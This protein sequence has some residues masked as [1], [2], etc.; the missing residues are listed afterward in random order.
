MKK[1]QDVNR[2]AIDNMKNKI[3]NELGVDIEKDK[4]KKYDIDFIEK[5]METF[6]N[7]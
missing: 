6:I 7:K 1:K 2:K 4:I 5:R 3:L